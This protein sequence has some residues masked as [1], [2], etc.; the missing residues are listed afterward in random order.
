MPHRPLPSAPSP[1][2]TSTPTRP[3]LGRGLPVAVALLLAVLALVGCAPQGSTTPTPEPAGSSAAAPDFPREVSVGEQTVTIDAKPAA[4]VVLSPSL[5][6]TVY[7][8][9][10]G[11]QVAA[12]DKLSN[13]PAE[14]KKTDLDAFQPNIEAIVGMQPDLVLMSDDSG[15][16]VDKLTELGITTVLLPAAT[17]LDEAYAQF[18]TIGELTG[19]DQAGVD[20][21]ARVKGQVEAAAAK[22]QPGGTTYYWELS[23][24]FYSVTGETFIGSI[25]SGFELT[26]I[27]DAAPEAAGSGGYPQLNQEFIVDADPDLIFTTY[28]PVE[29][30]KARPGW[31]VIRAVKDTDGVVLLDQDVASRW[32]P[33]IG[34]LAD[35]VATAVLAVQ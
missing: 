16:V 28:T 24:D 21:A 22:A 20:L 7:A 3:R 12:V 27:A 29:E 8:L 31:D 13:Y 25:M 4:V 19:N 1:A 34:E 5:T 23:S 18:E 10:A 26:S 14:A 30:I 17:S 2:P 6:E 32:G 11:P 33:R 35:Q 15:G 9:G